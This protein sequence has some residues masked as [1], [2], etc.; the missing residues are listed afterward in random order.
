MS[1][2]HGKIMNIPANPRNSQEYKRGHR[3]ARHAA[4]ELASELQAENERLRDAIDDAP[5]EPSCEASLTNGHCD[6][7]KSEGLKESGE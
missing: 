6:C 1:D 5:H 2:L 7:W 3:D 4:A